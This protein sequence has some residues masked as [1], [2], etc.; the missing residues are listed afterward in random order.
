MTD[1][2]ALFDIDGTL[3]ITRGAGSRCILRAC[4]QV[5]DSNFQWGPITVGTLDPQIFADL[6]K[7]NRIADWQAHHDAYQRAYFDALTDELNQRREDVTLMPGITELLDELTRRDDIRTGIVTGNYRR[8]VDI[9]LNAA[10]IDTGCFDIIAC[11]EDGP[12]RPALVRFA[13]DQTQ[14]NHPDRVTVIG[15][16]PRDI[17]CAHANGCRCLAVA[18]GRY[19]VDQLNAAGADRVLED[20]ADRDRVMDIFLGR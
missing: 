19:D 5:F 14:T 1:R 15:D 20:L 10:G 11:A 8:A 17:E 12:D 13:M 9:K 2:L 6:C 16:T 18:T 3:M 7:H 4:Q